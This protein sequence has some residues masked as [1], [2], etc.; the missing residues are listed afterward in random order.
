MLEIDGSF[1]EGGG[2]VLRSSLTLSILCKKPFTIKNIRANRRK[3]G[4]KAQHLTAIKAAAHVSQASVSGNELH[5]T[6]MSFSPGNCVPGNYF[7]DVQT[8]GATSLVLQ[9]IHLPLSFATSPSIVD[10]KGGT[11]VP[12]S[13]V[14]E[15]LQTSWGNFIKTVMNEVD[16]SINKAGFFPKGQGHFQA[17]ISPHTAIKPVDF[18]ERPSIKRITICVVSSKLPEHVAA[19]EIESLKHYLKKNS[20]PGKIDSV[21]VNHPSVGIGN[22]LLLHCELKNGLTVSFSEMGK[23]GRPAEKVAEILGKTFVSYWKS[24]SAVD[25]HLADQI[26]LPL[27]FAAAPSQFTVSKI[28]QHLLT[29]AKIIETFSD[30]KIQIDGVENSPGMVKITPHSLV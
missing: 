9:T 18:M 13:P 8:A 11:H 5:S 1:G 20:I 30:T 24:K 17:K 14:F 3:P 22:C 15:F 4:L 25:E 21:V 2:Q 29:N 12:F 23:Q 10:I 27:S 26:L 19:R 16:I 28:T 7:F 6:Q